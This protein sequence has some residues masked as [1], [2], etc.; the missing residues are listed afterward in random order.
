MVYLIRNL[1]RNLK[2]FITEKIGGMKPAYIL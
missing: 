2:F 1:K